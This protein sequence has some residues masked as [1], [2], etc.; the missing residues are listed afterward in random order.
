VDIPANNA[1]MLAASTAKVFVR[2][3][4]PPYTG[5]GGPVVVQKGGIYRPSCT[6]VAAL[7]VVSSITG[8]R[9][10]RPGT[11]Q[12]GD[13]GD[14]V[15]VLAAPGEIFSSIG[16]ITKDYLSKSSNVLVFGQ[17][18]DTLGY[19]MPRE[20]WDASGAQGVG[21]VNNAIDTGNYEES[22]NIGECAGDTV[23]NALLEVGRTLGVMGAGERR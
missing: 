13:P 1:F 5:P 11:D 7:M 3:M 22:L 8:V 14:S 15:T 10:G 19:L 6:T 9:L 23:Q 12:L 17:T 2:D 20:Q 16:L 21:L 18:N 4:L